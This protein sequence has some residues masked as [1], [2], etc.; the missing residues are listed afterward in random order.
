MVHWML[1][2]FAG[3]GDSIPA[4]KTDL[5]FA[6]RAACFDYEWKLAQTNNDEV[7]ATLKSMRAQGKSEADI[8]ASL[9][10]MGRQY[11]RGTC[12]PTVSPVTMK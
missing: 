2:L 8:S 12:I 9:Q 1:V 6:E 5:V 10:W 11:P 3:T 4:L 7:N